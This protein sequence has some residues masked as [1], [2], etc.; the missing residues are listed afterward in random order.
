MSNSVN[1]TYCHPSE[2]DLFMNA[3]GPIRIISLIYHEGIPLM[4]MSPKQYEELD[5]AGHF[6]RVQARVA[7]KDDK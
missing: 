1:I 2:A 6:K 4:V 5:K 3:L 7:D